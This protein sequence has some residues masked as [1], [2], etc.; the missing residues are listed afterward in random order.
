MGAVTAMG[1]P[2]IL[3]HAAASRDE[4]FDRD[5]D[6][7][8]RFKAGDAA[9]FAVLVE[10]NRGLL[11]HYLYRMVLNQSVAEELAQEVFVRIY[12]NRA[13]YE[14]SARFTTWFFRIATNLALNHIRD[15]KK[16]RGQTSLDEEVIEGATR[17]LPDR[18]SNVEQMLL[19]QARLS[20]IRAAIEKL[21]EKQKAAVLMHKYQEMEY[22]QI[23]KALDCSEAALKSLLF[24]A[25]ESLRA[26]LAHFNV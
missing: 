16:E 3:G 14:P 26:R 10:R 4:N 20:E 13:S 21:P 18:G 8:L 17:Q 1:T 9:C 15:T 12:R 2:G 24:R 22:A 6:L 25:Y 11:V 19:K 23:A 5:A 7:M